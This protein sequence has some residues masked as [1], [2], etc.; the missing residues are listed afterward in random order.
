MNAAIDIGNQRVKLALFDRDGIRKQLTLDSADWEVIEDWATNHLAQ[1]IILSSV[2][3]LPGE[4][5]EALWRE[6]ANYIRL[7][8]KTP[9]PIT[10]RYATPETL[11]KDRLAAVVGAYVHYPGEHCLVVDA[12][13]CITC[14]FLDAEGV[15]HGG[16]ISPGLGM[17]LQ[18]MHAFT[19]RLPR[20]EPSKGSDWMGVD[21]AS[22]MRAGA[23]WGAAFEVE[24]F[25]RL[26]GE[27]YGQPRLVLTG[28]DADFLALALKS[29]I[30]VHRNLVLEGLNKIL[31]YNVEP[32]A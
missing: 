19:A 7:D 14:D 29:K 17:R 31:E 10:N 27:R 18:A 20:L 11:G 9:L 3:P 26:F 16:S 13:T 4:K 2:G 24:G 25:A 28:G 23:Q 5:L 8:D 21:T 32:L 12:G 22:A 6:S 15:F 30:F 1:N